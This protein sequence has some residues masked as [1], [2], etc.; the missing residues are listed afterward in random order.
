MVYVMHIKRWIVD[1]PSLPAGHLLSEN[2]D[3]TRFVSSLLSLFSKATTCQVRN[4]QGVSL[5]KSGVGFLTRIRYFHRNKKSENGFYP[6]LPLKLEEIVVYCSFFFFQ[7]N[8]E[9]DQ[10]RNRIE[11]TQ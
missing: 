3:K 9:T 2:C 11:N 7:W 1:L 5:G 4:C 8:V 10:R 6:V